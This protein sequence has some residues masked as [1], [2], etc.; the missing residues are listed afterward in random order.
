MTPIQ[1]ITTV[2]VFVLIAVALW[3]AYAYGYDKVVHDLTKEI[4]EGI[5]K[6]KKDK[7]MDKWTYGTYDSFSENNDSD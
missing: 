4:D 5:E 3:L 6:L 1:I 2:L 7:F